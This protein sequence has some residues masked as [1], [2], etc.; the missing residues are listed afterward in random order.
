MEG[1]HARNEKEGLIPVCLRM[2]NNSGKKDEKLEYLGV[3][4]SEITFVGFV[5]KYEE[6]DT[7]TIVGIWDQTGYKD[8]IFYNKSENE[9][10]SGLSGFILGG[11]KTP[12]RIFGKAKFFKEEIRI[13][14]AKIMN[15]DMNEFVYHKLLLINDWIY[16]TSRNKDEDHDINHFSE[17]KNDNTNNK[18]NGL[19]QKVIDAIDNANRVT[20]ICKKEDIIKR[21]GL[22]GKQLDDLL[23]SLESESIIY[24]DSGS[25]S[26]I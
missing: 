4:I 2:L 20:G 25:Y 23:I 21:S 3:T 19:K 8:V 15:V 16:L 18:N 22:N 26:R 12:V 14:G 10:H 7:K 1:N 24:N 6:Q 11:D 9:A 13:D 17:K 5:V